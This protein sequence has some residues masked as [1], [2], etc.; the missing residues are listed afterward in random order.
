MVACCGRAVDGSLRQEAGFSGRIIPSSLMLP[1]C[2]QAGQGQAPM[3]DNGCKAGPST[4]KPVAHEATK[5][6][7][8]KSGDKQRAGDHAAH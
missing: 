4:E 1:D 6:E 3:T 7:S 8:E 5:W 2:Y